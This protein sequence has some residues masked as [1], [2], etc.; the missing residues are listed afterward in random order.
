MHN[1]QATKNLLK[2]LLSS[3]IIA[4]AIFSIGMKS[5][6]VVL[7]IVLF[8]IIFISCVFIDMIDVLLKYKREENEQK[9]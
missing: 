4:I 5:E 9:T 8:I 6:A 7:S 3:L 1:I 2:A